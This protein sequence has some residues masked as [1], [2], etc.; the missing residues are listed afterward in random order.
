LTNFDSLYKRLRKLIT[1]DYAITICDGEGYSNYAKVTVS[2]RTR[3][4]P[5]VSFEDKTIEKAFKRAI[6]KFEHPEK[7]CIDITGQLWKANKESVY[8]EK[9][10]RQFLKKEASG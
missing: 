8:E 2:S 10:I 3:S 6:D 9:Y 4:H 1:Y 7:D 5:W